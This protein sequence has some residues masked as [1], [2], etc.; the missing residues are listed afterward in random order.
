MTIKIMGKT[1]VWKIIKVYDFTSERKMMSIVVE[2]Q[3]TG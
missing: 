3:D 1:E 2:N